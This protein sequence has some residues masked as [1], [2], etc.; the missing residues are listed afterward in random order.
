[1]RN[2]DVLAIASKIVTTDRNKQYAPPE[3]NFEAIAE[4]WTGLLRKRYGM[5]WS[6]DAKD[7]GILMVGMKL[8]REMWKHNDDNIVDGIG[9]LLCTNEVQG[10]EVEPDGTRVS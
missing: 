8:V 4:V 7:V 3:R 5:K 6:L 10:S 2:A 1:M 9:Y